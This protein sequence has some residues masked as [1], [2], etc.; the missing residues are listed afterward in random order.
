LRIAIV[1]A[2][3]AG[4]SCADALVAQGFEVTLFDKAR[5]AGGRMSTRRVETPIGT[6]SFDHGAQYFTVRDPAFTA[7]VIDWA[8]LGL[9]APWPEV[10]PD[11][12]VGTPSMNAPVRHMASRH[13]VHFQSH[14]HGL[15]R[16][17]P[18]WWVRMDRGV[19]GPFDAV[20]IALPSEQAAA[21]L[22]LH[23][24]SMASAATS[25]RSQP[26]W[27][28]MVVFEHRLPIQTDHIRGSGIISWAARNSAKPGRDGPE[29]WVLQ[30]AGSWS[31]VH[32][33]DDPDSVAAQL[34]AELAGYAGSDGLPPIVTVVAHRWRF[35]MTRGTD[36]GA[37]WNATANLGACGDW[38][39]GPRVELAWLS[40]QRLAELIGAGT[41]ARTATPIADVG[42]PASIR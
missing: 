8:R 13:R 21:I 22:G 39:L 2:G 5:G 29:S 36:R 32:L 11:A 10:A 19:E 42:S 27:T 16:D 4:L 23:M 40:G 12:W 6:V 34:L 31:G 18:H 25:A 7:Q 3:I 37:L 35:A 15:H 30:A 17:S 9:V 38:L 33:D 14:V 1:G 20:V 26:C 24:L 28:A 41:R